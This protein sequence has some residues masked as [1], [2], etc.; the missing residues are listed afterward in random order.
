M[1][2]QMLAYLAICCF[3]G[4]LW[5]Y[6]VVTSSEAQLF[7]LP[8]KI[9]V[10]RGG[11]LTRNAGAADVMAS[12]WSVSSSQITIIT[13]QTTTQTSWYYLVFAN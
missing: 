6:A 12:V 8:I 9:N 1:Q 4:K 11:W 7:A 3:A 10:S 2:I 5:G 13:N